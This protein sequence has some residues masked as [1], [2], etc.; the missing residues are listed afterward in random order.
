M[1]N[2]AL[3]ASALQPSG[4]R[5]AGMIAAAVTAAVQ[6]SG[7]RGCTEFMAQ[8]SRDHP[9]AAAR[10]MPWARRLTAWPAARHQ[11]PVSSPGPARPV[12]VTHHPSISPVWS[13]TMPAPARS[14]RSRPHGAPAY[15]LARPASMWIAASRRRAQPGAGRRPGPIAVQSP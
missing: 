8:A 14:P 2:A 9:G 3:S 1:P 5:A 11:P 4:T 6:R 10:R 15:Y 13:T 12:L 7:T